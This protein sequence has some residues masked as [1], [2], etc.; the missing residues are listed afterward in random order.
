M[1]EEEQLEELLRSQGIDTSGD[2]DLQIKELEL[3]VPQGAP[4]GRPS[5]PGLDEMTRYQGPSRGLDPNRL[6]NSNALQAQLDEIVTERDKGPLDHAMDYGKTIGGFVPETYS[7]INSLTG[8]LLPENA[9]QGVLTTAG[10]YSGYEGLRAG[11]SYLDRNKVNALTKTDSKG[12]TV[13]NEDK[14]KLD[15]RGQ[16]PKRGKETKGVKKLFAGTEREKFEK[17]LKKAGLPTIE[18]IKKGK[19]KGSFRAALLSE[20]DKVKSEKYGKRWFDVKDRLKD[21]RA[22]QG[23]SKI[24]GAQ[25]KAETAKNYLK[26][27]GALTAIGSGTLGIMG[28][29]DTI[30]TSE[31]DLKIAEEI[32]NLENNLIPAAEMEDLINDEKSIQNW[33]RSN[34]NTSDRRTAVDDLEA[35]NQR[36]SELRGQYPN[37]F[38]SR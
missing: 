31:Q 19:G 2:V 37:I 28:L 33:L 17:T 6:D 21:T 10:L 34:P 3:G 7:T 32:E 24:S 5:L 14:L 1:T 15:G 22:Y 35:I 29:S 25:G 18:E 11:K 9:G 26:G 36:I 4:K 38:P 20:I 23:Y 30:T 13:L 12:K 8:G 16:P 27:A